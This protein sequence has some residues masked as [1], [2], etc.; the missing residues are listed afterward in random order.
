MTGRATARPSCALD[1]ALW[2]GGGPGAGKTTVARLLTRRH[3]LRWYN[4][5]ARTWAHRDRAV[6]AGHPAALRF[7]RLAPE[8]RWALPEDDL[9]EMALHHDR[10]PMIADDL[11]ALP[12]DPLTLAE[13][14]AVTPALA[15]TGHRSVWLLP[16][17]EV[18]RARLAER[19]LAPGPAALYRRLAEEIRAEVTASGGRIVEVDG[20]M[21]ALETAARVEA[22]FGAALTTGPRAT[23]AAGRRTL[24]RQANRAVVDQYTAYFARS[25]S[26][27]SVRD[28]VQP[29][30]CECGRQGCGADVPLAVADFPPPP[31]DPAGAAPVLADGHQVVHGDG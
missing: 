12:P 23:T 4:A 11:R 5:D 2:L 10:G 19:D 1:T 16:A 26:R 25:W 13:G 29:F 30:L 28:A 18:Q 24:L 14:T 22:L 8:A 7:E 31:D 21:G 17:P 20:R 9:L 15:G 27:G 6:A 3:G